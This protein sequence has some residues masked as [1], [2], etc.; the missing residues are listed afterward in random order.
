MLLYLE[1]MADS[2]PTKIIFI[3]TKTL[4]IINYFKTLTDI[5][6]CF[7]FDYWRFNL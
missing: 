7:P 2:K 1:R 3:H 4:Q 6:G 5:L